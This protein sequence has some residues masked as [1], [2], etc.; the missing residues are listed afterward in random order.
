MHEKTEYRILVVDD[1]PIV[2][3]GIV[4]LIDI[5]G[6]MVV[7]GQ[8]GDGHEVMSLIN[9]QSPDAVILDL[10]LETSD[11]LSL[12]YEI[13]SKYPKILILILSMHDEMTHAL[14][15]L[16]AGANGYLNKKNASR[17]IL[18]AL[19]DIFNGKIYA[20]KCIIEQILFSFTHSNYNIS[21][22]SV[23]ILSPRE[24]QIYCL[25][26]Q[27]LQTN[28]IADKLKCSPKTIE[29]HYLRIRRKM[30]LRNINELIANA[31][32]FMNKQG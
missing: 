25:Y 7:C 27:G 30:N 12:I 29:T 23:E 18:L 4:R 20:S 24:F 2:R 14:P 10:S 19:N 22:N 31:S 6:N 11:G 9:T 3:E 28:N 16:K 26:G 32:A 17:E 8:T 5:S 13:K 1:H 15:C 21:N